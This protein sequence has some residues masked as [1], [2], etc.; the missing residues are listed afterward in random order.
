M[1]MLGAGLFAVANVTVEGSGVSTKDNQA[2][3]CI[4]TGNRNGRI[5]WGGV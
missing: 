2:L 5:Y 4:L 3:S 1:L